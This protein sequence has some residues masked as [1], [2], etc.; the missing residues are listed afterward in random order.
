MIVAPLPDRETKRLQAL[1][2]YEILDTPPDSLFERV[3][4][5]AAQTCDAP[6]AL[7]SLIDQHRQWFLASHGLPELPHNARDI[8]FCA[9]N[10]LRDG[11]MEVADA[12]HDSRFQSNQLVVEDPKIR[13]YAGVPLLSA[14]GYAIGTLCVMDRKPRSLGFAQRDALEN[15][16]RLLTALLEQRKAVRGLQR[17]EQRFE[18]AA[19]RTSLGIWDW[20]IRRNRMYASPRLMEIL[21]LDP[22]QPV[23]DFGSWAQA[24]HPDDSSQ[25]ATTLRRARTESSCFDMEFRV[26]H[27]SGAYIWV[28]VRGVTA[29]DSQGRP[30][31]M[32]GS[33]ADISPRRQADQRLAYMMQFDAL[34]GLPNRHLV[35]ERLGQ[36]LAHANRCNEPVTVVVLNIG[37]VKNVNVGRSHSVGDRLLH[38]V[39]RRLGECVNSQDTVGRMGGDEF[40]IVLAQQ[41][42]EQDANQAVQRMLATL[43]RPIDL[44]GSEVYVCASAGVALSPTHARDADTLISFAEIAMYRARELGAG[45][46]QFFTPE[47]N[48]RGRERMQLEVSLRRALNRGEFTLHYQ[49]KVEA[50]T[51]R[52]CGAEALLRWNSPDLGLVTPAHFMTV[53]EETGLVVPVGLWVLKSVCRQIS[54]WQQWGLNVPPIAVN[55]SARQFRQADLDVRLRD[56]IE[57]AGLTPQQLAIEITESTLMLDSQQAVRALE[58]LQQLGITLFVDDFGTGYSSLAYLKQFPLNALK[59]D[60]SFISNLAPESDDTAI[61]TAIINLAHNLKLQVVAEG[62]ETDEQARFLADNGCDILQGFFF[63]RPLNADAF[64]RL[65]RAGRGWRPGESGGSDTADVYRELAEDDD[66]C[67]LQGSAG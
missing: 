11:Y 54:T 46:C 23:A 26:R 44:D 62:V 28:N 32:A 38:A 27:A 51:G 1:Y 48:L 64:A 16:A 45:A 21:G 47:L 34:T 50:T 63:A 37:G 7:V 39:A 3:T 33:L 53:L 17:S 10:I 24:V 22:L 29:R 67:A 52:V 43:A 35:R 19:R 41:G 18:Y 9:L 30:L 8:T 56:L 2:E 13:F 12:A 31:R 5:L 60:R 61:V 40:V 55:L 57:A 14:D 59:I 4:S 36:A 66:L 42:W 20:D 49:P 6:I 58:S 25:L 15:L 65:L